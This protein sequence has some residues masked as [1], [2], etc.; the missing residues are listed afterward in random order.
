MGLAL[1][2]YPFSFL[3]SFF[4]CWCWKI[5]TKHQSLKRIWIQ[6]HFLP[7]FSLQY[8]LLFFF[9]FFFFIVI[10]IWSSCLV[11]YM[12]VGINYFALPVTLCLFQNISG[13][14]LLYGISTLDEKF[15]GLGKGIKVHW[16]SEFFFLY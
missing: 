15:G 7:F 8:F 6:I 14:I 11:V 5:D 3:F 4:F 13:E 10:F 9:N 1:V 12:H 2:H 16:C